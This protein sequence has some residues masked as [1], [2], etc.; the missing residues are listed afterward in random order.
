MNKQPCYCNKC[1]GA[2]VSKR[3]FRRH[4]LKEQCN[5]PYIKCKQNTAKKIK[6]KHFDIYSNQ[7]L[8]ISPSPNESTYISDNDDA[9]I[10]RTEKS[11]IRRSIP[12]IPI[13]QENSINILDSDED[14]D[15]IISENNTEFTGNHDGKENHFDE[16]ISEYEECEEY[17]EYEDTNTNYNPVDIHHN[18][19]ILDVNETT[20]QVIF[21]VYL[22]QDTF[23]LPQTASATLLDF[24]KGLLQSFNENEFS[25]FPSTIYRADRLFGVEFEYK[26][27]I[28]CPRCHQLYLPD[29]L[30]GKDQHIKCKCNEIMTKIVRTSKGNY[31]I[32]VN[33]N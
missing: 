33:L 29:I 17:E 32:K 27:Y 23:L 7:S 10:L 22:F 8:S 4:L 16:I 1:K 2:L 26:N 9:T 14:N 25:D 5:K 13:L 6:N 20:K 11:K 19:S 30:N 21:W 31:L 28:V 15:S 24:F 12:L 3:T 18:P